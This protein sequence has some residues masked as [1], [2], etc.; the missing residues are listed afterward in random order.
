MIPL[1]DLL[2]VV[3][4]DAE[5]LLW[6]RRL[7]PGTKEEAAGWF[8]EYWAENRAYLDKLRA[9]FEGGDREALFRLIDAA[10]TLGIPLPGWAADAFRDGWARYM[11]FGYIAPKGKVG[12][13]AALGGAF[14]IERASA[15]QPSEQRR[16][17]YM[18][19]VYRVV[20][21]YIRQAEREGKKPLET[22][23]YKQVSAEIADPPA[24]SILEAA[25]RLA[26][27]PPAEIDWQTIRAWYQEARGPKRPQKM[28]HMSAEDYF[29]KG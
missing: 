27:L 25:L 18:P 28:R 29:V 2:D 14:G 22:N 19:I 8:A 21:E 24:H 16:R 11:D 15:H 7:A 3:G 4:E 26:E 17:N 5:A 9:D 1:A 13:L 6:L 23:I 20:E 12:R 10:A